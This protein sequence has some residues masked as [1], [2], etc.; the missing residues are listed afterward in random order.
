MATTSSTTA[1]SAGPADESVHGGRASAAALAALEAER[2]VVGFA[3]DLVEAPEGAAGAL[4]TGAHDAALRV[5]L[6]ARDARPDVRQPSLVLPDTADPAYLRAARVL[7]LR[8]VV[9]PTDGAARAQVGPMAHAMDD[10]AVL[11][12]V[13]APSPSPG[14]VDPVTWIGTAAAAK[15]V[16]LH[17]DARAG[18]WLLA[19][20]ER[21]GRVGPTWT[22]AAP[23]VDSVA[24]DLPLQEGAATV[25]LHRSP[26][27]VAACVPP[28]PGCTTGPPPPSGA[29]AAWREVA[30]RGLDGHL[31]AAAWVLRAVEL[32]AAAAAS[33]A[34][35]RLAAEPEA[36]VLALGAEDGCDPFTLAEQLTLRGWYAE[37]Q[38]AW[39]GGPATVRLVVDVA[40]AADPERLT[41]TL[42]QAV[43]AAR[44]LGPVVLPTRVRDHLPRL[45]PDRLT[46]GDVTVLLD[47]LALES[48]H[49]PGVA[50]FEALLDCATPPLRAALL[51]RLE[52][53]LRRPV[54]AGG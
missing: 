8:P 36:G 3:L 46:T 31:V 45:D 26:V 1:T 47:A 27:A 39:R 54:R 43:R 42:E 38:P 35:V 7:G 10:Q 17:V 41:S 37:A 2:R 9:V 40:G 11:A 6:A 28:G 4:A 50:R 34:G 52:E 12:V 21:L 49:A 24:L 48:T 16:P 51:A 30:A 53:L 32:V 23:G 19:C 44:A 18:G 25:L 29:T 14:V 13:S 22:F 33:L 5:V 20:G 15:Q